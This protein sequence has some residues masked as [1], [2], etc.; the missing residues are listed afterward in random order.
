[1][2]DEEKSRGR[3]VEEL[4][5]LRWL[6]ED[7]KSRE[8][9]LSKLEKALK[10]QQGIL[11]ACLNAG[12]EPILLVDPEGRILAANEACAT[13]LGHETRELAGSALSGLFPRAL[14]ERRK[15]AIGEAV[16]T[17]RPV[18]FDDT[19]GERYYENH[20]YPIAD[21]AGQVPRLVLYS[22]DATEKKGLEKAL[23]EAELKYRRTFEIVSEGLFQTA[24]DGHFVSAN[25]ALARMFGYTS[26]EDLI[27]SVVD[28]SRQHYVHPGRRAEFM[29]LLE[30]EGSVYAFEV[31]MFRKDRSLIWVSLNA[32][33]VRNKNEI[34]Y[35]EGAMEDITQRKRLEAQLVQS[36]KLETIGKLTGGIAHKFTDLLTAIMG[37][38]ELL[39]HELE[40]AETDPRKVRAIQDAV[41]NSL[42]L[43]E[44]LHGLGRKQLLRPVETRLDTV[45]ARMD[46]M[47]RYLLGE[48]IVLDLPQVK[49]I[50][51]VKVDPS[52]MEQII[53]IL[54]ENSREAMPRGG[55]LTISV[56]N[57]HIDKARDE[58]LLAEPPM[59]PGD[60]VAL[61]ASDTGKGIEPAVLEHIFEPFFSIKPDGTGLGLSI[62]RSIVKQSGGHIRVESEEGQGTTFSI[63]FPVF[64]D[65]LPDVERA[66][67]RPDHRTP[68]A[69]ATVMVVEDESGILYWVTDVLEG[70][71]LTVIS[72]FDAEQA[73]SALACHEGPLDLLIA[74]LILPGTPG[75]EFAATLK[76][77]YPDMQVIFM[78]GYPD[79]RIPE[80]TMRGVPFLSKPFSPLLLRMKVREVLGV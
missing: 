9:E 66:P 56:D 64:E 11:D 38:F 72:A 68:A 31:Q 80:T 71:G 60:Y 41:G 42:K 70:M 54:A 53:L 40:P 23:T 57:L 69:S 7:A 76:E 49:D 16:L 51:P 13:R 48:D 73:A 1:M 18:H 63:Y 17:R 15:H 36:Q 65:E 28:I 32:R 26:P 4:K 3:L 19:D 77:R 43:C 29:R 37:N 30:K 55:R 61:I 22:A 6:V 8:A 14:A 34:I 33:A 27:R 74:D 52:L 50:R 79:S 59:E 20:V 21:D 25:N 75:Q 78:S 2:N 24:P 67:F 45:V 35:Y 10:E 46:E 5:M 39:L 58:C 12:P 44:Q 47:L 62:V